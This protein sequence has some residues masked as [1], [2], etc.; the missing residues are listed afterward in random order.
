VVAV[1]AD[2]SSYTGGA[3]GNPLVARFVWLPER[4]EMLTAG[5]MIPG[6]DGWRA[7]SG[8][9]REQLHADLFLRADAGDLEPGDR[10]RLVRS[11][12]EMIDE[13]SAPDPENFS[14][15]EPVMGADGRI[16]ALRF[17]FPPYQVGPYSDG[18]QSVVV[19]AEVL[20]PHVADDY[21]RLFSAG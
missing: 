10:T 1:A 5:M 17:V 7:L 18:T 2:G 14:Q 3:H 20:L 4:Q 11:G 21:R 8:Y 15:F 6:E 16:Q 19:P 12:G 13:G 9:V